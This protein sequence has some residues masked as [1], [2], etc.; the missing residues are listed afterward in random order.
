MGTHLGADSLNRALM[1]QCSKY[2]QHRGDL[3]ER[4]VIPQGRMSH[5]VDRIG[6]AVATAFWC[7]A[8]MFPAHWGIFIETCGVDVDDWHQEFG[9]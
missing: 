6:D 3:C 5:A 8:S 1:H 9:T 7:S 2:A 4:S